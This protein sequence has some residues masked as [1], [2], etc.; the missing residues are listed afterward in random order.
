MET[1]TKM[2]KLLPQEWLAVA[3]FIG[4][5]LTL[6]AATQIFVQSV[7]SDF[8]RSH[9]LI[10][11]TITV[12]VEGAVKEGAR[13]EMKR[14]A[15]IKDVLEQVELAPEAD[16]K[17]IK[18]NSKVRD[19]QVIKVPKS[20]AKSRKLKKS[21]KEKQERGQEEDFACAKIFNFDKLSLLNTLR[22]AI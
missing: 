1:A 14:G 8:E 3:I 16:L 10:D 4:I 22:I 13:L 19:G 17:G 9:D 6:T 20:K 12:F 7:P 11:P 15:L 2:T 21:S 5:M 18:L